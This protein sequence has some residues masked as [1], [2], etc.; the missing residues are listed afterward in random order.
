MVNANK[1]KKRSLV[2][3]ERR[4][5]LFYGHVLFKESLELLFGKHGINNTYYSSFVFFIELSYYPAWI[6]VSWL[7]HNGAFRNYKFDLHDF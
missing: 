3:K 7:L 1:V 6:S 5:L 2:A 4:A